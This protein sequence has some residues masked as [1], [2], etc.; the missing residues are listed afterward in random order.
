MVYSAG[1]V[2]ALVVMKRL[3]FSIFSV[4]GQSENERRFVN[5]VETL[6]QKV[7]LDRV[8]RAGLTARN[9]V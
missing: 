2:P 9:L 8:E 6:D 5:I 4:A 7:G 3:D 1:C